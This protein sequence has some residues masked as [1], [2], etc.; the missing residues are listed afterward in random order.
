M[1]A[2]MKD[3]ARLAGVSVSTVSRVLANHPAI[4]EETA[5]RV[6]EAMQ[7]LK[8]QPNQIAR[9]L[10]NRA[11]HT[12]ALIMPDPANYPLMNPFFV[13]AIRGVSQYL[14]RFN[15]YLLLTYPERGNELALIKDLYGSQRTDGVI[16]TSVKKEDGIIQFLNDV[17]HPFVVIGHPY[18][19]DNTLWVD[20]DNFGIIYEIT[21]RLISQGHRSIAYLGG[22]DEYR[23]TLDRKA[24]YL[25]ALHDHGIAPDERLIYSRWFTESIAAEITREILQYKMPDAFLATD[26]TL[27]IGVER[28]LSEVHH[29]HDVAV[30]GFNNT[31]VAPYVRP[32]LS[33]V[34]INAEL[35]G[36]QAAKL[37]IHTLEGKPIHT[38][39]ILVAAKFIERESSRIKREPT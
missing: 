7:T 20:N 37:L 39:H 18:D 31:Q 28:T 24:G 10:S 6:R 38:N 30:I 23:V 27:A 9:S 16:L 2:T 8:Y 32:S 15:Y 33:S 21:S 17:E 14:H 12:V 5:S 1:S 25:K 4:S 19:E 34:E 35:L 22:A 3:V 13:N 11:T 26:D 36:F 29:S